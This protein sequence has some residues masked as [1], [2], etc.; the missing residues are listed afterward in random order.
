MSDD[1]S[2]PREILLKAQRKEKKDLQAQI[3]SLK[4]AATK[5]DKKKKKE[6]AES[7]VTLEQQLNDKHKLEL[8]DFDK[9]NLA[10]TAENGVR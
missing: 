5:G 10:E 1:E 2:D 4:K 3:Q 6:V 9:L 8:E 7:I